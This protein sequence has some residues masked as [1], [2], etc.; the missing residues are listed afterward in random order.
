LDI[1]LEESS[2]CQESEKLREEVIEIIEEVNGVNGVNEPL[3]PDETA[4]HTEK[5]EPGPEICNNMEKCGGK[6]IE[7]VGEKQEEIVN[8][9]TDLDAASLHLEKSSS[10]SNRIQES[11][12]PFKQETEQIY[13]E[14]IEIE[15]LDNS[16]RGESLKS[17][18]Y[19]ELFCDTIILE[20]SEN[21]V[22]RHEVHEP[23]DLGTEPKEDETYH[24]KY[25]QQSAEIIIENVE[26]KQD[27]KKYD[28]TNPDEDSLHLE[29]PSSTSP[30]TVTL[31]IAALDMTATLSD[32]LNTITSTPPPPPPRSRT[33][34]PPTPPPPM[35]DPLSH[36]Q[37]ADRQSLPSPP[38]EIIQQ[39]IKKVS[40]G[41]KTSEIAEAPPSPAPPRPAPP[42]PAPP[43]DVIDDLENKIKIH[44]K[45]YPTPPK[46][47]LPPAR[48]NSLG[49]LKSVALSPQS[50]PKQK[51]K[52]IIR[53]MTTPSP[54]PSPFGT[55]TFEVR[56]LFIFF[57]FPPFFFEG[58]LGL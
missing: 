39:S 44:F 45:K 52:I 11:E 8:N 47:P 56:N 24:C 55:E 31:I 54:I 49:K 29:K 36:R 30:V 2:F 13:D 32:A 5:Q 37:S 50:T 51:R 53:P 18:T 42:R 7:N 14:K 35:V 48:S 41:G 16:E 46:A 1:T 57:T 27:E 40:S 26:E 12:M 21:I 28:L 9:K 23:F 6:M 19:P 15:T 17:P 4:L 20:T 3:D 25:M 34:Q 38:P 58:Q 43:S 10:I 33:P 22:E